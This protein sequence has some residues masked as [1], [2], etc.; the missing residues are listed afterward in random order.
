MFTTEAGPTTASTLS[1]E[2]LHRFSISYEFSSTLKSNESSEDEPW[3]FR[4]GVDNIARFMLKRPLFV[5]SP[6]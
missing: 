3:H 2:V 5:A 1:D 4:A 6:T